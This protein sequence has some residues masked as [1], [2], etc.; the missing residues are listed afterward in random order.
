MQTTKIDLV[1][2]F[3]PTGTRVGLKV[4]VGYVILW[5]FLGLVLGWWTEVNQFCSLLPKGG[6]HSMCNIYMI[7]VCILYY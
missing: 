4:A 6:Q 3:C 2:G 5:H 1:L 7:C